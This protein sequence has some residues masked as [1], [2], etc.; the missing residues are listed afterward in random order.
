[1]NERQLRREAARQG[2]ALRKDRARAPSINHRGGY[3]VV[4]A[5]RNWVSPVSDTN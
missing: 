3:M 1:M 2:Y 5:D 4:D